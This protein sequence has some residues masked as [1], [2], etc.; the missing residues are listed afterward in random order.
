MFR[1]I[2]PYATLLVVSAACRASDADVA[3]EI[4]KLLETDRAWAAQAS[5]GKNADSVLAYWTDDATVV[6]PGQPTLKGKDALRKMVTSDFSAPGF[7]IAWTPEQAVVAKSGDMG[8]TTGTNEFTIPGAGPADKTTK[9]VGRYITVWRKEPDG[10]WRCVMD[11]STPS[12][13][14]V[15]SGGAK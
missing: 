1:T 14:P 11:Y 4:Q 2:V 9:L 15:A 12:P 8:Y 7:H 10:R 3:T 5:A 13:A 6:M